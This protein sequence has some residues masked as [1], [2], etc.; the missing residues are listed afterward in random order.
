MKVFSSWSGGKDSALAAHRAIRQGHYIAYLVNFISEDGQR[1]RS[2]G[3][4]ADVLAAQARATGIPLIQAKTSWADYEQNFK[5]TVAGLKKKGVQGGVFGD[6]DLEEHREWVERVCTETGIAPL[7][8]L[9]KAAR[10]DLLAEFW[11]AGFESVVVANKLEERLLG[12]NLDKA[13]VDEIK[14]VGWDACGEAGEY[15]SFVTGGPLFSRRL[16][17]TLG[18]REKRD[19]MWFLDISV[20]PGP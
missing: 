13:F 12:R 9:W 19:G 7:L 6:I 14:K 17:V 10:H 1:S 18:K 5:G 3:V 2:H 15:H 8:P 16:K 20:E 11:K 4:K